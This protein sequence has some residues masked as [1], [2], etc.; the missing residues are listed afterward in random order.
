MLGIFLRILLKIFL[1]LYEILEI[2][3]RIGNI[4]IKSS[5]FYTF[6]T[7]SQIFTHSR[8][9]FCIYSKKILTHTPGSKLLQ[10]YLIKNSQ[11]NYAANFSSLK[12]LMG[13]SL[14]FIQNIGKKSNNEYMEMKK[15]IY[16]LTGP[17]GFDRLELTRIYVMKIGIFME[18]VKN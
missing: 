14:D 3:L 12:W 13:D 10:E 9:Y 1:R 6:S 4:I 17:N 11:N 16:F 5:E 8:I 2:I 7:N 15:R 18:K